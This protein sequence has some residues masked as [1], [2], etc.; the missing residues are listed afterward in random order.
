MTD[1][2][3]LA[4]ADQT[5]AAVNHAIAVVAA[6]SMD[7]IDIKPAARD[8][9]EE[10][11]NVAAY[12]LEA[13][14]DAGGDFNCQ[15]LRMPQPYFVAS[16]AQGQAWCADCDRSIF[17]PAGLCDGCGETETWSVAACPLSMM[18]FK[19]RLCMGCVERAEPI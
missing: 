1:P 5:D 16:W 13:A 10:A 7:K 19:F 15:H 18:I 11:K 2:A 4:A 9:I 14:I 17:V 3:E 6:N 12:A 8:R